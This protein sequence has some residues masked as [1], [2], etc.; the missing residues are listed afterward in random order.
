MDG[1]LQ[2]LPAILSWALRP[3]LISALLA[4]CSRAAASL[5][6][7][8]A[9]P[10]GFGEVDAH[11][12]GELNLFHPVSG[13]RPVAPYDRVSPAVTVTTPLQLREPS[14]RRGIRLR[15]SS[16]TVVLAPRSQESSHGLPICWR[17][18]PPGP[19]ARVFLAVLCFFC[20]L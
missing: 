10:W 20:F 16:G 6:L 2:R 18:W 5:L 1:Q 4:L 12:I 7:T 11:R 19:A 14:L 8:A 17:T 13:D 9:F 15:R 3:F